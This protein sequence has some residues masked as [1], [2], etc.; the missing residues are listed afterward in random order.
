MT[1]QTQMNKIAGYPV[2]DNRK[3][4]QTFDGEFSLEK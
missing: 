4:T 1:T 3:F 2:S